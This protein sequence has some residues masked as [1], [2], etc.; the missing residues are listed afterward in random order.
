MPS[1]PN[2]GRQTLRTRDWACQWCGY[3]L[4]SRSYK[5]IDKTFKQLQEERSLSWRSESPLAEPESEIAPEP[6]LEPES[7]TE[8]VPPEPP[9]V[10][11]QRPEAPEPAPGPV[12]ERRP[13]PAA[14]LEAAPLTEPELP[15]VPPPPAPIAPPAPAPQL[16]PGPVPESLPN[17]PPASVAPPDLNTLTDGTVLS[18]D[19]LDAL[20]KANRLG[21]HS[22]L[23]NKTIVI[24]GFVDKV[25]IRDHIDVRYVVL[26]GA[27]KNVT[28]TVRCTFGK[29]SVSQME[30]LGEGQEVT[31]RGKYDNYGKNIIFKDCVLA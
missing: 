19:Q 21:V 14:V 11:Q 7:E 24:T 17:P 4:L 3:P 5:K 12:E 15:S 9:E 23:L 29:E 28:W 30:R 10:K 31:L 18:V 6:A 13:D 26:T 16:A 25:F 22:K 27:H 2:C 8:A 1:C 20:F